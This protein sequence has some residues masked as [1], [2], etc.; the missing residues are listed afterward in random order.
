MPSEI[1]PHRR[2]S[3]GLAPGAAA[4][5]AGC[6]LMTTQP[7]CSQRVAR[8]DDVIDAWVASVRQENWAA[9]YRLLDEP[10]R[11]GMDE[12]QFVAWCTEHAEQLRLQAARLETATRESPTEVTAWLPL[13][14]ARD[15]EL[16]WQG[17]RWYFA[18]EVP[19]LEGGD[20]PQETL[21]ALAALLRGPVMD[22]M[23][24]MLSSSAR[25]RY[26]D[27]IEAIAGALVSGARADVTLFGDFA[28]VLVGELTVR[29]RREDGLWRVDTIQQPS[30]Y[31]YYY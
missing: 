12:E 24:A 19:L 15:A 27:E 3:A 22:D 16:V 2:R 28:T 21:A 30:S 7:A 25:S 17:G 6:A 14:S 23:L 13:D 10:A 1:R 20:T 26:R 31:G 9:A 18:R 29:M 4:A 11:G 5:L 8:P